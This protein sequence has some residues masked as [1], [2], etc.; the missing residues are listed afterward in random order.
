MI[1]SALIPP[2]GILP[3]GDAMTPLVSDR[4]KADRLTEVGSF[5]YGP[6]QVWPNLHH[7]VDS[8]WVLFTARS[9]ACA[10]DTDLGELIEGFFQ[11]R[12]WW[13]NYTNVKEM[14]SEASVQH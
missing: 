3:S 6:A 2:D 13:S 14:L 12:D 4:R 1:F 8:A 11:S 10:E 7:L 9:V 5:D